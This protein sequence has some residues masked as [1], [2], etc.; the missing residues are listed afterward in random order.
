MNVKIIVLGFLF[1]IP[2]IFGVFLPRDFCALE[3][4]GNIKMP[5][6]PMTRFL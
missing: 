5:L 4:T 3:K 1:I 2:G 6:H